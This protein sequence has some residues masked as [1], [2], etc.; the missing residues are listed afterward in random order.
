MTFSCPHFDLDD[1]GCKKLRSECI[2]T[3]RGCVLRGKVK[4]G[5]DIE[6]RL[7]ELEKRTSGPSTPLPPSLKLRRDKQGRQTR[8]R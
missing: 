1:G 2:P 5:E 8:R 6:K 3:R 4:V 7:K